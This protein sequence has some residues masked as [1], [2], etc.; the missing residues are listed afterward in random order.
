MH[1]AAALQV[2]SC[3]LTHSD[4]LLSL[5]TASMPYSRLPAVAGSC[6]SYTAQL[7]VLHADPRPLIK[8]NQ[9]D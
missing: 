3:S 9:A 1:C 8:C 4:R 5:A 2:N 6:V 7:R